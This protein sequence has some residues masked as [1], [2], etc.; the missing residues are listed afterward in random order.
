[1]SINGKDIKDSG[2]MKFRMATVPLGQ[3]ATIGVLRKGQ[4]MSFDVPAMGPPDSP[5]RE[6]LAVS[7]KNPL[8]GAVVAN[9][10][11]ALALE[12]G[13]DEESGVVV[14]EAAR[15]SIASRLVR[16]GDIIAGIGQFEV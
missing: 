1:T 15:G 13:L 5:A 4:A 9:L 12:L 2:E 3:K 11:P 14:M 7:G 10:N 8:G 16:P 6:P